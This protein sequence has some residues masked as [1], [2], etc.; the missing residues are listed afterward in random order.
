MDM[1]KR[2]EECC[3]FIWDFYTGHY[4]QFKPKKHIDSKAMFEKRPLFCPLIEESEVE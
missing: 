1:P 3:F 4:C 2:C